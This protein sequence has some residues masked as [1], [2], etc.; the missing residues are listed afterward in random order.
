MTRRALNS[1]PAERRGHCPRRCARCAHLDEDLRRQFCQRSIALKCGTDLFNEGDDLFGGDVTSSN[2]FEAR[3][4]YEH[5][6]IG[7]IVAIRSAK[8]ASNKSGSGLLKVSV[9]P[10]RAAGPR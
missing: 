1:T 9:T 8:A 4:G 5:G 6:A 7:S 10:A 3:S 2:D